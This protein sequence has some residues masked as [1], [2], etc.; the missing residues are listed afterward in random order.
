V[1]SRWWM[2]DGGWWMVESAQHGSRQGTLSGICLSE[3]GDDDL[4]LAKV[5]SRRGCRSVW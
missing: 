5:V 2:V 1:H 3:E 4:Q